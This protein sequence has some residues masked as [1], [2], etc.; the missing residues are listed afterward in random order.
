MKKSRGFSYPMPLEGAEEVVHASNDF[1]RAR[2]VFAAEKARR[3]RGRY[4]LR[5]NI[6][7]LERWPPDRA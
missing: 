1:S 7:A 6:R 3:P 5:Q 2:A 4:T